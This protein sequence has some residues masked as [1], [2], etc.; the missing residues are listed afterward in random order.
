MGNRVYL[1][2]IEQ[3]KSSTYYLHWNGC[4]LTTAP[5]AKA[6]FD[7]KITETSK[8]LEFYQSMGIKLEKVNAPGASE[9]LEENGHYYMLLNAK[10][11]LHKKTP[12][13][14]PQSVGDL[15]RAFENAL[16]K[17]RPEA[18]DHKRES[19]WVGIQAD[20]AKFFAPRRTVVTKL[21]KNKRNIGPAVPIQTS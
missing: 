17:Y 11:L 3:E 5:V 4:P 12:E 15:E 14:V 18:R 8:V 9:F 16:L 1:T 2:I 20:A 10:A 19:N 13:Q 7:H 6:V 21:C